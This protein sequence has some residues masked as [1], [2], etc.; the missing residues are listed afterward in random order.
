MRGIVLAALAALLLIVPVATAAPPDA[1]TACRVDRPDGLW[2]EDYVDRTG[3]T[4]T[5]TMV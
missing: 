1:P 2:N 5:C 3:G 4:R